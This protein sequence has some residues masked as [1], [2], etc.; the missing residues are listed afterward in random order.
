MLPQPYLPAAPSAVSGVPV[1]LAVDLQ[2]HQILAEH[3]IDRVFLPASM[4]KVMTVF[5]AFELMSQGKLAPD[6][7]LVVDP[8]TA[9]TWSSRGTGMRLKAGEQVSVDMLLH[10]I[11]TVSANDASVV[12]AEGAAG[13]V[14]NWTALM[15]AEARKLGMSR[16]RF[17]TPNGWPDGGATHVS[18]ADL[19]RL[20]SVMVER[21]PELYRRYFGKKS[22]AWNGVTQQ[23]HDPT[24]GV[25]PGADGIKTGHTRESGYSF[26][27]T[28]LRGDRRVMIVIG[29]ASSEAQRAEAARTLIEWSFAAWEARPLFRKGAVVG[30][31]QVQGGNLRKLQLVAPIGAGVAIP[32]GTKPHVTTTIRYRGPLIAPIAKGAEVAWLEIAVSGKPVSRVPLAAATEVGKAGPLDR[33][34]NGLAGWL[35]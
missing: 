32:A 23:N 10:G 21:H 5:V 14:E 17:A 2:A 35:P 20:G 1:Y 25:V 26:L 19:I 12:L 6:L 4:T 30:E 22:L 16:S 18:A 8:R 34:A 24:V 13:S 11:T 3:N 27:G 7:H 15:N 29:G 31:A 33:L 28:A 9:A